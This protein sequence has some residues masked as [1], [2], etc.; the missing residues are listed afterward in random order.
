MRSPQVRICRK[1]GGTIDD[2]ELVDGLVMSQKVAKVAGGSLQERTV[3]SVSSLLLG[4]TKIEKAKIGLIQ[5][6]LSPPKTDMENNVTVND[7]AQMDR[8]LALR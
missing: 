8:G 3:L 4:P 5:F 2:S 7:Y 6:C 1:L